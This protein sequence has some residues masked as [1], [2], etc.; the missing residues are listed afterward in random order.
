MSTASGRDLGPG[1][2]ASHDDAME[3]EAAARAANL[4]GLWA[5][6]LMEL[7]PPHQEDYAQAVTRYAN[8]HGDDDAILRKIAQDLAG[9]G[10]K[11]NEDQVRGKRDELLAIARGQVQAEG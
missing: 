7:E 10:L 1:D 11:L 3:L 2:S 5:A 8:T 4:L 6:G 9:A